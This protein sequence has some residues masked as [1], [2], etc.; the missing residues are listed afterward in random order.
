MQDK[1]QV[2]QQLQSNK[3]IEKS[4]LDIKIQPK[5]GQMML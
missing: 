2:Q 3:G 4:A 5:Q 1:Q